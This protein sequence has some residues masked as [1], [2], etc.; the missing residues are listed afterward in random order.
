MIESI[1][2]PGY[3]LI[4]NDI[5]LFAK[6]LGIPVG[7]GRGSAAGSLVCYCLGI[8]DVD[9][10]KYD[11]LFERLLNPERVSMPDIDIDFCFERRDEVIRYVIDQYSKDNVCQIITFGTM[12]ARGVVRDGGRVLRVPFAVVG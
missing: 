5:V 9:P 10:L 3:F 11:L 1:D 12:A 7:P 2:F 8:T 6:S 4:V